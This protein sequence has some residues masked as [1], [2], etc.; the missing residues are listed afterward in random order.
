MLSAINWHLEAIGYCNNQDDSVNQQA[1]GKQAVTELVGWTE[2]L[3]PSGQWLP[4]G[5]W[6]KPWRRLF[7]NVKELFKGTQTSLRKRPSH[8][9]RKV[10]RQSK[11][12]GHRERERQRSFK[13]R[14]QSNFLTIFKWKDWYDTGYF[15]YMVLRSRMTSFC[16]QL[17]V[18]ESTPALTS[19]KQLGLNKNRP[20]H[21]SVDIP[22]EFPVPRPSD[23]F[24]GSLPIKPFFPPLLSKKPRNHRWK[25][26][27]IR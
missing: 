8:P 12:K 2:L 9:K 17:T 24:F 15:I 20:L 6:A 10:R 19:N 3:S 11:K 26:I 23:D 1:T 5:R 14:K 4:K 27:H 7:L 25:K 16:T 13:T 22:K 21:C 18:C